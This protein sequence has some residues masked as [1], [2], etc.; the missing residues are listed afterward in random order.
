[1]AKQALRPTEIQTFV[2]DFQI[3]HFKNR[4]SVWERAQD[5][6]VFVYFLKTCTSTSKSSL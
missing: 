1:M 6:F 5:P 4:K 2:D 3:F